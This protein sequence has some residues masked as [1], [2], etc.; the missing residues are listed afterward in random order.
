M[1]ELRQR[2]QQLVDVNRETLNLRVQQERILQKV[3]NG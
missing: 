1:E 3:R 2:L